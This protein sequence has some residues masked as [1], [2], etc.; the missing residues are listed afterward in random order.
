MRRLGPALLL[1]LTF[2]AA[3]AWAVRPTSQSL[4]D[5]RRFGLNRLEKT[6]RK[7]PSARS[8]SAFGSFNSSEGGSWAVRYDPRTGLPAALVGGRSAPRPGKAEDIA[9]TFL[10]AQ[11]N[12]LGVSSAD[13]RLDKQSSG[14]G[15]RHILYRQSYR[16]LPVEFASVKVHLDDHGSV[17]GVH[18]TYEPDIDVP[19]T[20]A[21]ASDAAALA[22]ERDAQGGKAA[23]APELVIL[24]LESTGRAH[25]AWKVKVRASGA[26][27]RYYVDATTGQV[28]FRYNN[29]RFNCLGGM[30]QGTVFGQVYD[31]DPVTTPGPTTRR[32]NHQYVYI[33]DGTTR[34]ETLYDSTGGDGYFCGAAMGKVAMSLQGPYVNVAEFTGP[35]AHYDNGSGVWSTLATP[36]SS[37][38]PYSNSSVHVSTIDLTVSVPSAVEFLPAF[39]TFKVGGFS[40]QNASD[41]NGGD[42]TDDDQ[43]ALYNRYDEPVASYIGDRGAFCAAA[44]HGKTM[45][46]VLKSN[47]S[48]TNDGYDVSVSS[49]LTLTAPTAPGADSSHTW[50]ATDTFKGL[51]SEINLFYHLNMMHDYFSAGVNSANAAPIV[52]PVVAMAHVGPNLVNA[53]YNPDYDNLFFGDVNS[54]SPSDAFTDD[55]TVPRHEYV[56][57]LM[58][59]IWSIQNFGQAG[60][61]SEGIADYFAASSLDHASIGTYVV[62]ALGGTGALREL[63]DVAHP[64]LMRV[65]SAGTWLGEIHDDSVFFSQALWDIRRDRIANLVSPNGR[66]CADGLAFQAL[67][68]FP[69]SFREFEDAMLRVDQL[70]TVTACGAA[71]TN[72]GLI[73]GAFSSHGLLLGSGDAYEPNDG[74]ET[75]IDISTLS[76]VSATLYPAADTD[77]WSFGAGPGLVQVTLD[78]P[79]QNSFYKGYQLMLY[80]SSRRLVATAAPPFDGYGTYDGYCDNVECTTTK[81]SV[82]LS[83]NNPTGGLLYLQVVGGNSLNGSASGVNS[84]VPYTLRAAYSRSGA[85]AGSIV[86]AAYDNDVISFNVDVSTFV[87]RQDWSFVAAQLRDQAYSLLPNTLTHAPSLAGD[88]LTLVS[89]AVNSGGYITGQ[90]RLTKGFEARFPSVGTIHLEV[91]GYNVHGSTA[92]LGVSNPINLSAARVEL[93][94]YNNLFNPVRGE[95]ATVKYAVSAPGRLSIKLYTVTGTHVYTLFDDVVPA[96]KGSVDWDGRNLAG[97]VV[98]SGVYVVR[99][100]GPG[101]DKTQKIAIIK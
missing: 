20:P 28:L 79:F 4:S 64:D 38:H 42:I 68:F 17:L 5:A 3:P 6:Q 85:L 63:D 55:A 41:V 100:M 50:V 49:Y 10:D 47:D 72:Q 97:S 88:Y 44:V 62:S 43:V 80:D 21:V 83:Y 76:V 73:S 18:S 23:G 81:S 2:I 94:A 1:I 74:F 7:P 40:G 34:A 61:I 39:T 30:T 93:T 13:L 48:G 98:A 71:N 11:A 26:A 45:H 15:H 12:L 77:F 90:V 60:A 52:R 19:T 75:A 16:G 32:F 67:L 92:S 78:L 36:I 89:P 58:E 27:W 9:R 29:L 57:Y 86:T 87:S 82:V 59:K 53:F 24:P 14:E 99:A 95:K 56:H 8:R 54:L 33:A 51:R 70:G 22:A 31:I 91:F 65:L 96:G 101:L 25:L 66:N 37:P 35:S 69:E 84:T 46:V